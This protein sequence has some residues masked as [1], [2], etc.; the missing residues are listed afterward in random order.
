MVELN[1]GEKALVVDLVKIAWNAGA[2]RAPQQAQQLDQLLRKL[3]PEG[4]PQKPTLVPKEKEPDGGK[5][6]K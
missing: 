3:M 5:R 4:V 2:V 6:P 1:D